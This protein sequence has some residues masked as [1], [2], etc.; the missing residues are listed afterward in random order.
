[1]IPKA[2][3]FMVVSSPLDICRVIHG[4]PDDLDTSPLPGALIFQ[5]NALHLT[6]GGRV[7]GS[8]HADDAFGVLFAGFAS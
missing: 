4:I 6:A 7:P 5:S 2:H 1:M 8:R 3:P